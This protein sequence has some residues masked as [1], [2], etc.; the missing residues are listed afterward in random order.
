MFSGPK[1]P[2]VPRMP[3]FFGMG[4]RVFKIAFG[5]FLF[6]EGF[7]VSSIDT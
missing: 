4:L 2:G 6:S 3:F 5:T 7:M 1:V